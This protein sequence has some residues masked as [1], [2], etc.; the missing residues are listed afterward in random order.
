M[1][2]PTTEFCIDAVQRTSINRD[3]LLSQGW[4]LTKEYP[5]FEDF[6]HPNNSLAH[7]SIGLYGSF[8]I[9]EVH[10]CNGT[11]EREFSSPNNPDL[12]TDDYF[13]IIKLLRI[14]L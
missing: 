8:S 13:Y 5:L 3:F 1:K 14:K 2:E 9:V 6:T 11:P 10:W 7:C 12:T 4:V